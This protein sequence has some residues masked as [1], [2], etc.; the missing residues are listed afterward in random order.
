[1]LTAAQSPTLSE[2]LAARLAQTDNEAVLL[3]LAQNP[4]ISKC[5]EA[6]RELVKSEA[7]ALALIESD[8]FAQCPPEMPN[9]LWLT[10]KPAVQAALFTSDSP[11][12]LDEFREDVNEWRQI[13]S[14]EYQE[15]L[16]YR[17]SDQW[18]KDNE[19]W[20]ASPPE[21]RLP[22]FTAAGDGLEIAQSELEEI[23]YAYAASDAIATCP[24]AIER[25]ATD[26]E[27]NVRLALAANAAA[28]GA[29]PD[30]SDVLAN[31]PVSYVRQA[32]AANPQLPL[33][34]AY[35]L[36]KD[37]NPVVRQSLAANA[38]L[39][40]LPEVADML[41]N[42]SANLVKYALEHNKSIDVAVEREVIASLRNQPES[43]QLRDFQLS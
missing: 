3:A 18:I 11:P 13:N 12:T 28:I 5:P 35:D 27:V 26:R 32:L 37:D 33:H 19:Y 23:R 15:Q 24:E 34:V 7:A 16:S 30:V 17:E 9:I 20:L 39:A 2:R 4:A 25:L 31:D 43:P 21:P 41:A 42:D 38:V 29:A 40:M 10:A 36:A 14:S 6:L 22:A 8:H 1:M